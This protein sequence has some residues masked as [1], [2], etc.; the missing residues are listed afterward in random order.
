MPNDGRAKNPVKSVRVA[1]DIVETLKELDGAGI[2]ELSEHFDRSKSSLHNYLATLVEKE[3]VVKDGD[4]Y[5]VGMRFLELGAYARHDEEI[6]HVAKE[7]IDELAESTGELVNLLT[8]EYGRG[9]YV[10][11][12]TGDR[13]VNVDAHVGHR[14]HLHNT[15]L[16][17]AMLAS[18]P[19]ERVESIVD[20]HGLPATTPNTI[21][22]REELFSAL[23]TIR[24]RGVA[25]D[26]EERLEGLRCVACAIESETGVEGAISVSAP[27]SRMKGDRFRTEI[28]EK[29]NDV[30]NIIELNLTYS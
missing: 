10:Y 3:Y 23:E 29:L 1:F 21:S 18:M 22:D 24:E 6:Y 12:R 19:D 16:G 20:T 27:T 26:D 14:V 4:E 9:I 13:A 7:E 8:E 30:A 5:R 2:S 25:Y 28:P 15:A 11:R 17:K